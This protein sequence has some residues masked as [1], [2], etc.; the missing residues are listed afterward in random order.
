MNQFY[1]Y[2]IEN[3]LPI[4]PIPMLISIL[5]DEMY[6]EFDIKNEQSI[7]LYSLARFLLVV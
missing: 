2:G 3:T 7:I 1:E 6:L 4:I 5:T